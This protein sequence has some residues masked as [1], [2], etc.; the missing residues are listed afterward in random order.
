MDKID[1]HDLLKDELEFELACRGIRGLETVKVM[2]KVLK[3]IFI[4]EREGDS[5]INVVVPSCCTKDALSQI[6]ICEKKLQFLKS[7]LDEDP[8]GDIKKRLA[9]R[10]QHLLNRVKL[11]IPSES[12]IDRHI[13]LCKDVQ[14]FYGTVITKDVKDEDKS[15]S[16]AEISKKDKEILH[17]SLG[18]EAIDILTHIDLQSRHRTIEPETSYSSK[19]RSFPKMQEGPEKILYQSIVENELGFRKLVP[20][21][22]WGVKFSGK[23]DV[24]VNAFLERI[25]ELREARNA[26]TNDLWRYA[27]DFFE[28]EALIWFRANREYVNSWEEL[29]NLLLV[30]FQRPYYQDEL[31]EEIKKRTQGKR[32]KIAIYL[33][34]MQNMFNRLPEKINEEQKLSILLKNIQPYFQ[35][36]VCRD[37]FNTVSELTSVLRVLERTRTNCENFQEPTNTSTTLEPDLAYQGHSLAEVNE[38]TKIASTFNVRNFGL[39]NIKCWN[40]R[41]AGHTFK[42]CTLPRQRLFCYKCGKFGQTVKNCSCSGN[43]K[44]EVITPAK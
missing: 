11:I 27:V 35:L 17:R 22:D 42:N 1:A 28:G 41:V 10:L 5:S 6:E 12:D 19:D 8:D 29:V 15:E 43:E 20:I 21:K 30:T 36:A 2:R 34:V 38:V 44:Q 14:I 25:A 39:K 18:E 3:Q 40:C 23:G 26:N 4:R 16:E 33:A 32:E 7:A 9:S 31:L 13:K 37:Q 24:S